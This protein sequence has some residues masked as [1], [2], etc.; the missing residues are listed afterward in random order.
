MTG[1]AGAVADNGLGV[2]GVSWSS[3]WMA[4]RVA[5]VTEDV[6]AGI[7]YAVANG[8]SVIN[9]S[10]GNYTPSKYGPDSIV[11]DAVLA[12][13]GECPA[14]REAGAAGAHTRRLAARRRRAA[15]RPGRAP[16]LVRRGDR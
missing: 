6:A 5:Y 3:R 10:F 1:V 16:P 8:A 13:S 15:R 14:Q 11:E 12:A 9:M 4:V 7:D 2:A